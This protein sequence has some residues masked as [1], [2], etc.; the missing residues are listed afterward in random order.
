MLLHLVEKKL[1]G[2]IVPDAVELA[3]YLLAVTPRLA[4]ARACVLNDALQ[5]LAGHVCSTVAANKYLI[6]I[7]LGILSGKCWPRFLVGE[8]F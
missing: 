4:I 6:E 7:V 2:G 5:F 8:S 3:F 1:F